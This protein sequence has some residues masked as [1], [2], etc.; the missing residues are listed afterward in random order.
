M[1]NLLDEEDVE[2]PEDVGA[3]EVGDVF[4]DVLDVEPVVDV[5]LVDPEVLEEDEDGLLVK[6]LVS[7][8]GSFIGCEE[9]QIC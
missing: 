9:N 5:L 3:G 6:Q 2:P 1:A 8:K 7:P 4:P